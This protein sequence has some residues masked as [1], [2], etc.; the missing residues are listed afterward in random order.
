MCNKMSWIA[1]LIIA[2]AIAAGSGAGGYFIGKKSADR[3]I[4]TELQECNATGYR[5]EAAL[6]SANRKLDSLQCLP[7]KVDT[8]IQYQLQVI[9]RIDTIVITTAEILQLSRYIKADTDTIKSTLRQ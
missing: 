2:I 1:G 3:K 5:N 4:L 9:E 7:A 6:D 8:I